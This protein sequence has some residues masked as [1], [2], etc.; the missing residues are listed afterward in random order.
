MSTYIGER[1]IIVDPDPFYETRNISIPVPINMYNIYWRP[2][3][4]HEDISQQK[5]L[6][7]EEKNAMRLKELNLPDEKECLQVHRQK[8]AK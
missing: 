1:T 3:F 6:A 4:Y 7:A 8:E 5:R 2:N